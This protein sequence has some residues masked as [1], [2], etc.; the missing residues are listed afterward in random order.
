MQLHVYYILY[1]IIEPVGEEIFGRVA[2]CT[3]P[4]SLDEKGP[5]CFAC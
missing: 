4:K 1:I 5:K 2:E 3:C